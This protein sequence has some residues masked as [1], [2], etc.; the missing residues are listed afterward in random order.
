MALSL[1]AP[2]LVA[3]SLAAV[4]VSAFHRRLPP[5]LATRLLASVTAVL[6]IAA[7]PTL[8]IVSI[9]Y[10]VHVPAIHTALGWCAVHFGHHGTT[11]TPVGVA[12]TVAAVY[13]SVRV[14]MVL[15]SY[16]R[17][18]CDWHAAPAIA[19]HPEP[20]ALT[21][22]G[23]GGHVVLSS[24][25]VDL[26][27]DSERA[28]VLAHEEAHGRCRHDRYFL[29]GRLAT[30]AMP[31]LRPLSTRLQYN[32]ERWADEHA[33][34]RCGDRRLVASTLGKVALRSSP[35][36]GAL[37]F[38][39]VGIAGRVGALLVPPVRV[40]HRGWRALGLSVLAVVGA[41]AVYQLHHVAAAI[42]SLCSGL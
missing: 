9:G 16:R 24:A 21:L 39:S 13:G 32:L 30:A 40:P 41:C 29:L 28:V 31:L 15:R 6:A 26:L 5:I 18:R 4:L 36:R 35:V 10:L 33:V 34:A 3:A 25:L 22:P 14:G 20:F 23:R 37:A 27:S 42:S 17:L 11:A 2:L 8:W 1:I 38:H 7:L 19:P 12:A